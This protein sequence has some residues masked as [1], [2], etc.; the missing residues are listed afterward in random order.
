MLSRR[1]F[2]TSAV[3][4][5]ATAACAHDSRRTHPKP[6]GKLVPHGEAHIHVPY[7]YTEKS[8]LEA[9]ELIMEAAE[10]KAKELGVLFHYS[11]DGVEEIPYDWQPPQKKGPA[12]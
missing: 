2:M 7:G 6:L 11:L 5:S 3:A 8:A 1:A 4:L 9:W 12:A 10:E